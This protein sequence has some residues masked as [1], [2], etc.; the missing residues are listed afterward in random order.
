MPRRRVATDQIIQHLR[1]AE[2]HLSQGKTDTQVCK[3]IGITYIRV[4]QGT[5][6]DENTQMTGIQLFADPLVK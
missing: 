5:H 1:E 6:V 3:M 4:P 2:V